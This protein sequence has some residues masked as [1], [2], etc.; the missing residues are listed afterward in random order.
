MSLNNFQ[1]NFYFELLTWLDNKLSFIITMLT[2]LAFSLNK[3]KL[4]A[5]EFEATSLAETK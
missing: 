2:V 5:L 1:F 4:Y 3:K